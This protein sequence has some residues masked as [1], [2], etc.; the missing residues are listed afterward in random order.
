M[1]A[2]VKVAMLIKGF[3]GTILEAVAIALM[4]R[5]AAERMALPP[6]ADAWK[7]LGH[8]LGAAIENRYTKDAATG[9]VRLPELTG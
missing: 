1:Q 9:S 2:R 3:G 7:Q 6:T 8:D 5:R 4:P